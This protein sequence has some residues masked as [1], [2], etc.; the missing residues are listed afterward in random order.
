MELNYLKWQMRL[1]PTLIL[2]GPRFVS[3]RL[4]ATESAAI[5]KIAPQHHGHKDPVRRKS[6]RV[7]RSLRHVSKSNARWIGELPLYSLHKLSN[8]W[9][10]QSHTIWH[11][12]QMY[13]A[14]PES[15]SVRMSVC[16]FRCTSPVVNLQIPRQWSDECAQVV[17][18]IC[19]PGKIVNKK[20]HFWKFPESLIKAL[21]WKISPHVVDTFIC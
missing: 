8:D 12:V 7:E 9:K 4:Q 19:R 2:L 11:P 5:Q 14:K 10:A 16:P 6:L 21:N 13:C 17:G 20:R 1:I 18:D 15:Q 3:Q